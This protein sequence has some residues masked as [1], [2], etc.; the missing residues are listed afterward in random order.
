MV[1]HQGPRRRSACKIIVHGM[2]DVTSR[3]AP[4]LISVQVIDSLEGQHDEC[5]IELD[6]RN[7][8]LQLPPDMVPLQVALGWAGTGPD[9]TDWGRMSLTSRGT[10]GQGE[11]QAYI[12]RLYTGERARQ[13]EFGGPGMELVFS[14]SV[15]SVE[16]GFGRRGGGRRVWIEGTSGNVMGQGKEGQRKSWGEGK[17]DDSQSDDSSGAGSGSGAAGSTAGA[18]GGAKIPLKQ[19]MQEV[20]GKAG[21]TVKLSPEMEKISR[22]FWNINQSPLDF[23]KFIAGKVG[24]VFKV[25]NGVATLVGRTEGVN[26]EGMPLIPVEAI[27]GVNLIGWRIKPYAGRP[28]WGKTAA[29]AFD[30]H[31]AEWKQFDEAV[32]GSTP[33]GG[34]LATAHAFMSTFSKTEA[35]QENT[36][37]ARESVSRRGTGW[38]LL[39]GEPTARAGASLFIRNARPGVDGEYLITEVEH[40]YTRG[41]GFTTRCNVQYPRPN[42][43][44]FGWL[45]D[46]GPFQVPPPPKEVGPEPMANSNPS[47]E[48]KEKMRQWYR[49]RGLPLPRSLTQWLDPMAPGYVPRP[50][51]APPDKFTGTELEELR[52]YLEDTDKANRIPQSPV[53]AASLLQLQAA[54]AAK[55]EAVAKGSTIEAALWDKEIDRLQTEIAKLLLVDERIR[56]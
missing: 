3:L 25:A 11:V 35:G 31:E 6:D 30:L 9:L 19:V 49:E 23:G 32:G 45:R 10:Q 1:E 36:G 41:V 47:E 33:F 29:R 53:I 8:E 52:K 15:S 2:Q 40:N 14:G 56:R 26:A 16:S 28:Q 34:V 13:M 46:P 5:H 55:A 4:Y 38:C 20:F 43:A 44:D 17:P 39:N 21:M 7:A 42:S 18:P 24:G 51:D 12:D 48:E 37:G 27:W 22:S 50:A 54:E